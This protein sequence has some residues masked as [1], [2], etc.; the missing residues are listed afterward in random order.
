MKTLFFSLFLSS[1]TLLAAHEKTEL[2]SLQAL[3]LSQLTSR[4][5]S[6]SGYVRSFSGIRFKNMGLQKEIVP[7]DQAMAFLDGYI[8][9][10]FVIYSDIKRDGYTFILGQDPRPTGDAIL[11]HQVKGVLKAASEEGKTVDLIDLGIATTPLWESAIREWKADGGIMITASHNPLKENGWKYADSYKNGGSLLDPNQMAEVL[12]HAKEFMQLALDGIIDLNEMMSSISEEESSL[13]AHPEYFERALNA[14]VKELEEVSRGADRHIIL[15]NDSN[16]G[17]AARVNTLALER[18]GF[19][20]VVNINTELGNPTH[21]IEPIKSAQGKEDDRMQ[22]ALIDVSQSIQ[23]TGA[24]VGI[25]YDFDADRGN[26]VLLNKK[27][28]IEEIPP[29]DVA[30]LNVALAL[31]PYQHVELDRRIAVVGHCATSGRTKEIARLL[32]AE[33]RTVEV[34]EINVAKK[35]RELEKQGYIVPIGIEGYNG[36]T[37]FHGSQCRDG[38]QTLLAAA[39]A[40]SHPQ[41]LYTWLQAK[42]EKTSYTYL[43]RSSKDSL[44]LTDFLDLLPR[45]T[46]IQDKKTGIALNQKEFK[47]KLEEALAQSIHPISSGQ[48]SLGD[49][50]IYR[51]IFIEYISETEVRSRPYN[52][53]FTPGIQLDGAFVDGG[54]RVRLVAFDNHESM[55]WLR[56]SKTENGT[57]RTLADAPTEEEARALHDLLQSLFAKASQ[58]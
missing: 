6:D 4:L 11:H 49:S 19:T 15:I 18:L 33:F 32:G 5:L 26:L 14:Y 34:G 31:L 28:G 10:K 22:N 27:G 45:Y 50:R 21:I 46:S 23:K 2:A 16:G 40:L 20:H 38:L 41:L 47:L 58:S 48:Y 9:T 44:F 30:A 43:H 13:Q 17:A 55:M 7:E 8:Y 24:K 35:M 39:K 56:G 1:L 3:D 25:V 54:W 51:D 12:S 53:T 29:Q 57:Y 42:G 52:E 37:I 36:G